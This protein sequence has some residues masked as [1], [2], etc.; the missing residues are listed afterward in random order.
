MKRI[1]T[2]EE[3]ELKNQYIQYKIDILDDSSAIA[4]TDG[5]YKNYKSGY[6]IVFFTKDNKEIFYKSFNQKIQSHKE[7]LKLHSVGAECEAAKYAVQK[8]IDYKL[9]QITIY[10]DYE[11]ILKWLNHE[12]IPSNTYTEEY[13][14]I[15]AKY[16]KQIKIGFV[17]V[18][19]HIGIY[20]NELADKIAKSTLNK[21]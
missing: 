7:I 5:T 21:Y 2:S 3:I 8:A 13:L 6:G 10:Y 11:G 20:Y 18:P 9:N 12:W 1:I 14:D 16:S 19:S 15:M 17:K 4:F